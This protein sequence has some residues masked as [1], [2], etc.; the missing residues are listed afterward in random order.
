MARPVGDPSLSTGSVVSDKYQILDL[1]G[2]G[3]MGRV[4]RARQLGLGRDVALKTLRHDLADAETRRFY[5]ERFEVEAALAASLAHP[6]SVRVFD[7]GL[8]DERF[9]LVMELLH[10]QP[11]DV[12]MQDG[13]SGPRF[14]LKVA[15]QLCGALAEAHRLGIVHRDI[16]PANVMLC[17]TPE[18]PTFVKLMDFGLATIARATGRTN[19]PHA[20]IDPS[21][22]GSFVEGTAHYA[23]P[24]QIRDQPLDGR[25]DLYGLG[26]LMLA[27]LTGEHPFE[28]AT[29][30]D[31]LRMQLE[32]DPPVLQRA[33]SGDH[34]NIPAPVA[35]LIQ[36]CMARDRS[37]RVPN[38]TELHRR[39]EA[40]L[41][42]LAADEPPV[43]P[44]LPAVGELA[45]SRTLVPGGPPTEPDVPP[46]GPPSR[47]TIPIAM[48]GFIVLVMVLAFGIGVWLD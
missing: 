42:A 26:A 35:R 29:D 48:L 19:N 9:Y 47:D 4:Y 13:P 45:A 1:I 18:A 6:N 43:S 22:A 33:R 39:L 20:S 38:A 25:A 44:S 3:G 41:A 27:L 30:R 37:R 21:S 8:E 17:P 5:R 46:E 24:E 31:V 36:D 23:A 10:G 15:S 7:F 12:V 34:P 16:K 28:G 11:L 40:C 14:T 32:T 2:D